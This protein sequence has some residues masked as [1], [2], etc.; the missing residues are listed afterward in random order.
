MISTKQRQQLDVL[1]LHLDEENRVIICKLCQFAIKPAGNRV[2]RHLADKHGISRHA[3]VGLRKI[4]TILELPDPAKLPP[5][6]D[7]S[8][9]HPYLERR[10]CLCCKLCAFKTTSLDLISRH[11]PKTHAEICRPGRTGVWIRDYIDSTSSFQSWQANDIMNAWRID[12]PVAPNSEGAGL[13][14]LAAKG[15]EPDMVDPR[16]A[17]I[18][19]IREQ[20]IRA[21][22]GIG[23]NSE[24]DPA[25]SQ[26]ALMTNWM[27]RTRWHQTFLEADR[28]ALVALSALPHPYQHQR[29]LRI[30]LSNGMTLDSAVRDEMTLRAI[31]SAVDRLMD[32]AGDTIRNTDVAIRRWLRGRFPERPYK[33]PFELVSSSHSEKQY[34]RLLKRCICIWVRLWNMPPSVA[35]L[36][37]GRTL[38]SEQRYALQTLWCDANWEEENIDGDVSM[39]DNESEG[40][41]EESEEESEAEFESGDDDDSVCGSDNASDI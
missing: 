27:R 22:S 32:R 29:P 6:P 18:K 35:Q 28:P 30:Q 7:G 11:I 25:L 24:A 17:L 31:M 39:E 36:V 37:A 23:E 10:T 38:T 1:E 34:Q 8:P 20:E 26:P 5:R 4:L 40:S 13:Q 15:T 41:E 21:S 9:L 2:T 14:R 19:R 12:V 33:A 16:E 3:R